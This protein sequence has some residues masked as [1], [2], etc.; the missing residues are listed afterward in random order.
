MST[1]ARDSNPS[2]EH[3]LV[4]LDG[5]NPLAFLAALGTLRSLTLASPE[6][7]VR[8]SWRPL[9]PW[10]PVLHLEQPATRAEIVGVL[11]DR[12]RLMC[13]HEAW[14]LGPDL[15]VD[16]ATF[17]EYAAPAARLARSSGERIWADFASAF[18][19]EATTNDAGL[20]QDTA[21][22]T[23]NGAG[24]QHFLQFMS[25]IAGRTT[26]GHIDKAL[27]QPWRYDDPVEKQTLR[28]DPADDVRRALRWRDPSGDPQR[29]RRGGML[30]A[31]RLAIEAMPLLP[32]IPVGAALRTTG[33][34]AR[35]GEG[36]FWIWPIWDGPLSLDVARS[37]L[38][39]RE[40]QQDLADRTLRGKLRSMGVIEIYRS[41]RL[42]VG[43]F[44]NFTPA[45]PI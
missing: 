24:H 43:K 2:A 40:L 31:N 20:I 25:L 12:L 8:M 28:W 6:Q 32:A 1:P 23:M 27:F 41:R 9:G 39:L 44:R 30:G 29:K 33:F 18:G 21:L 5:G 10:R 14:S 36:T 42:T 11:D 13:D 38:A 3:M 26:P 15:T 4:G 34:G 22:R 45:Q 37:L 19:C 16:A 7:R 17:R 35:R